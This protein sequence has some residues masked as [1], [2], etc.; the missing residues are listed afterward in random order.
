[1]HVYAHICLQRTPRMPRRLFIPIF[2]NTFLNSECERALVSC[3]QLQWNKLLLPPYYKKL[4]IL[5]ISPGLI[6]N[7]NPKT[8]KL[9][10]IPALPSWGGKNTLLISSL[11]NPNTAKSY[12]NIL[13]IV[14]SNQSGKN[15]AGNKIWLIASLGCANGKWLITAIYFSTQWTQWTQWM[16]Q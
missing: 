13:V 2:R 12:L 8:V 15:G 16:N 5:C 11:K 14:I 3:V 6:K 10:T 1:M 4:H 9:S 7:A